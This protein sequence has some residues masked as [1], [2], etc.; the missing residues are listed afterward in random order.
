MRSMASRRTRA[1]PRRLRPSFETAAA[2]PPQD[3]V[4]VWLPAALT[5]Q[6]LGGDPRAFGKAFELRPHHLR[7]D[8]LD[9]FALRKSAIGAGNDVLAPHQPREVHDPV[10]DEA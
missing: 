7:M 2:R 8:A 4:G 9:R 10:G 5:P 1:G 3:E 6:F